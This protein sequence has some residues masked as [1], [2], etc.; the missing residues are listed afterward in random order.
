MRLI[1]NAHWT[2][3]ESPS[4]SSIGDELRHSDIPAIPRERERQA[5]CCAEFM[6]TR[7]VIEVIVEDLTNVGELS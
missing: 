7:L 4:F 1:G 2:S 5:R 3:E 6:G